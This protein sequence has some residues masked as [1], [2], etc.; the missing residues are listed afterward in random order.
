VL[1]IDLGDPKTVWLN[2]TNIALG[3]VTLLCFVIVGFGAIREFAVRLSRR[4]NLGLQR[5]DHA[6]LVPGLGTR[7]ADGGE[8]P[9]HEPK[10]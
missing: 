3:F 5:D 4:W 8:K 9:D 10:P 2:L 1:G 6:F 7:M